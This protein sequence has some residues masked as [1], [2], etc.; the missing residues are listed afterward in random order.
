MNPSVDAEW[1]SRRLVR[2]GS[3]W[4]GIRAV[5]TT[6]S[7]NADLAA[8]ARVG[9][10]S[11]TVLVSDHQSAGRGRF[12]RVWEAPPGTSL[13]ISVLLRPP[14]SVPAERWLWLPLVTGLA[15]A[16]GVR[17][18]CGVAVELKWPNDVLVDGRKL[19]GILSERVDGPSGPAAVIGMGINTTL[20]QAQLPVPTAT[21]LALAGAE[22]DPT[23]VVEGVLDALGRWYTHWLAGDDLRAEY[24]AR[25]ASVGR[26]VRVQLGPDEFVEGWANGVDSDGRLLVS[27][28]GGERPFAAGDVVHLR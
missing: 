1:L 3:V 9:A 28:A 25:C 11:G 8:V 23:A 21:S 7:T 19:C 12:A 10:E 17:A 14:A 4:T 26:R 27:V 16:D 22:V 20:S 13:A 18:A 15:V 5:A 6:G 24:A 2:V